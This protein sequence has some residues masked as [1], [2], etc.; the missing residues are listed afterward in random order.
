MWN[1]TQMFNII[2]VT[3]NHKGLPSLSTSKHGWAHVLELAASE[4]MGKLRWAIEVQLLTCVSTSGF[5]RGPVTELQSREPHLPP[6]SNTQRQVGGR[7]PLSHLRPHFSQLYCP[8]PAS[9]FRSAKWWE[10][11]MLLVVPSCCGANEIFANVTQT[12]TW[13]ICR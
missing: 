11:R 10:W 8:F 1:G 3:T 2:T 9:V 7:H 4:R 6:C 5:S 12:E 13:N